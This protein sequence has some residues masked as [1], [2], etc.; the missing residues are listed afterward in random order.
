[1]KLTAIIPAF[2]EEKTLGGV[3]LKLKKYVDQIIIIDDGSQDNTSRVA[4]ESG[5]TVYRHLINRGLG[6]ALGTGIEAALLNDADIVVTL[7]ADEQHDPAE[8]PQLIKPI[9][10]GEADAVIG[11]RFLVSQK[12]PLFRKLGIPFFNIFTFLLFGIKTTDSQSGMRAFNKKAAALLKIYARGVLEASPEILGQIQFHR[13]RMKEVPI[14]AIYT[15][16]SLAKGQ[17]IG[18]GLKAIIKLFFSIV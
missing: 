16:Y 3:I 7:D 9:L 8:I 11:S 13:L 2:N 18:P 15:D 4:Q 17:R 14:R 5:A 12:M 1:M 10:E 6:G